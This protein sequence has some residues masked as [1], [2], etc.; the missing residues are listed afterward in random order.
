M[1]CS[2]VSEKRKHG[3]LRKRPS[4]GRE[5]VEQPVKKAE[6]HCGERFCYTARVFTSWSTVK[7]NGLLFCSA[8]VCDSE[9]PARGQTHS[10]PDMER[11]TRFGK[12][13]NNVSR[14]KEKPNRQCKMC[15][16]KWLFFHQRMYKSKQ[17]DRRRELLYVQA[18]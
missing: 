10:F 15:P 6:I 12:M 18:G 9:S 8:K 14:T 13:S 17:S 1:E 11:L 16:L 4:L 3:A 5:D 7:K 2:K